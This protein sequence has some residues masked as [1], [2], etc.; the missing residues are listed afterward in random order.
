[1]LQVVFAH[2]VRLRAAP[3]LQAA[4]TRNARARLGS[5]SLDASA[6]LARRSQHTCASGHPGNYISDA[7]PSFIAAMG[8]RHKP[9][10]PHLHVFVHQRQLHQAAR[11][12]A[13]GDARLNDL[14]PQLVVEICTAVGPGG[15][16]RWAAPANTDALRSSD[17]CISSNSNS[18]GSSS[19][20]SRSGTVTS[21]SSSRACLQSPAACSRCPCWRPGG[22]HRC[23]RTSRE[24]G[25]FKEGGQGN[26][27]A[28]G[29]TRSS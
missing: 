21:A 10:A 4:E 19:S 2:W 6:T 18:S 13:G 7:S 14:H 26:G 11:E 23:G 20:C 15:K 28:W 16:A 3:P 29:I 25:P 1:M 5:A 17:T 12:G 24:T 9:A 27:M 22:P 8:D